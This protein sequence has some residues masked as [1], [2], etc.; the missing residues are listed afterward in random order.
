M[1]THVATPTN[2]QRDWYVVDAEGKTL[3]RLAT[4]LADSG[5][6]APLLSRG[7]VAE[8]GSTLLDADGGPVLSLE[9]RLI[10][11]STEQLAR[12]PMRV[13][14]GG[15]PGKQVAVIAAM[16]SGLI[17][18]IV[19]DGDLLLMSSGAH[20]GVHP[21]TE[22]AGVAQLGQSLHCQQ[23]RV[24][25]DVAGIGGV[26][27]EEAR[28]V[29]QLVGVAVVERGHGLVVAG[30]RTPDQGGV[31]HLALT[32]REHRSSLRSTCR[33]SVDGRGWQQILVER[34]SMCCHLVDFPLLPPM[35]VNVPQE[36]RSAAGA[37]RH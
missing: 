15:G 1:K 13:A 30:D 5:E 23:E 10:G 29:V 31:V 19:T 6:L 14:L 3:G 36:V 27:G 35:E 33:K 2:R 16:K 11:I 37:R 24:V 32:V 17:D 18:M 20:D 34:V 7:V 28:V 8:I 9:H 4:Q 21:W 25:H 12:V 22:L 26:A